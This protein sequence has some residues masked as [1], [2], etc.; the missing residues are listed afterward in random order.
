MQFIDIK[1]QYQLYREEIDEAIKEVLE[2][3][4]FIL[5]KEVKILEEKLA[6]YV[7]VKHC[8]TASSGTDTLLMA[9]IHGEVLLNRL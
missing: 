1:K 7:G 6:N 8:I 4:Q 5:G 2:G 3:G 9:L